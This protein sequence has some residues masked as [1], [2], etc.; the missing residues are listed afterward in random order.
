M[1]H[2]IED[3]L[4]LKNIKKWNKYTEWIFQKHNYNKVRFCFMS[5]LSMFYLDTNLCSLCISIK[6]MVLTN[7]L[8]GSLLSL[9]LFVFHLFF[10]VRDKDILLFG[11]GKGREK[12]SAGITHRFDEVNYPPQDS[13][14]DWDWALPGLVQ[15]NRKLSQVLPVQFRKE[16]LLYNFLSGVF[17][18][19]IAVWFSWKSCVMSCII[20]HAPLYWKRRN[21]C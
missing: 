4:F 15:N 7:E 16:G 13:Q 9:V 14:R 3:L 12:P 10:K 20:T 8:G 17:K 5:F 21:F 19:M 2:G 11:P 6:Q 1:S 18:S